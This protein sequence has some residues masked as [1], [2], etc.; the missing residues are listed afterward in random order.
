VDKILIKNLKLTIFS[1]SEALSVRT[2]S[3]LSVNCFMQ[4]D[5]FP[6]ALKLPKLDQFVKLEINNPNKTTDQF[7]FFKF[8]KNL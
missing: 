5:F 1:I 2:E 4:T 7:P 6:D 3:P 8:F